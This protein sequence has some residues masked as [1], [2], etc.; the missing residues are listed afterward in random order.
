[1]KKL[2]QTA[3]EICDK[4]VAELRATMDQLLTEPPQEDLTRLLRQSVALTERKFILI[5]GGKK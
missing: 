5:Q 2:K 4:F 1:M 3:D